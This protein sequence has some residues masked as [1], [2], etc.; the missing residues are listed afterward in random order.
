MATAVFH[1]FQEALT[2]I[3]RHAHATLVRVCL[4]EAEN[5]IELEVTDN[6]KGI[7]DEQLSDPKSFGL[8][9]IRERVHLLQGRVRIAG[10]NSKGTSINVSIPLNKGTEKND[11]DLY[12]R[13]FDMTP[14][15]PF[16]STRASYFHKS[17]GGYHGAKIRRY[18]DLID[19]YISKENET[20]LDMLNTRYLIKYNQQTG[21]PV[22]QRR[23]SMLGN[24]WFVGKYTIAEN[25][26]EEINLVNKINPLI[27]FLVSMSDANR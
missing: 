2:N 18:Q 19:R 27:I 15:D 20:V 5:I 25:A 4:R 22:V 24:A 12:F 6:G 8:T 9:G 21:N 11:K 14:G 16:S 10:I 23:T 17:I 7:V 26:D 3:L 1:I 13:V